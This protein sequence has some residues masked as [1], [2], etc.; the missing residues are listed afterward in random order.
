MTALPLRHCHSLSIPSEPT[1]TQDYTKCKVLSAQGQAKEN[2]TRI[3]L[4]LHRGM[5]DRGRKVLSVS[6]HAKR[7]IH[8]QVLHGGCTDVL[9][10]VSPT[11]SGRAHDVKRLKGHRLILAG[12]SPVLRALIAD[13]DV[14]GHPGWISLTGVD[15]LA[16]GTLVTAF[17]TGE[18]ILEFSNVW[19]TREGEMESVRIDCEEDFTPR[20]RGVRFGHAR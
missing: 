3:G 20:L 9:I 10:L 17:Y 7:H 16:V 8:R 1:S 5:V 19:S 13:A 14:C 18:L 11:S 6:E 15:P 12:W 4:Q 2:D